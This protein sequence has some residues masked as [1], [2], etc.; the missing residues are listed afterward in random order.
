MLPGSGQKVRR[1]GGGWVLKP[2]LVFNFDQ[3]CDIRA[4][5]RVWYKSSTSLTNIQN[6]KKIVFKTFPEN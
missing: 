4:Y 1:G 2:I 6:K 5:E 3:K